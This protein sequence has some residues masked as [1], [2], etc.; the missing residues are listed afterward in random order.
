MTPAPD[1]RHAAGR[2]FMR[3]ALTLWSAKGV[4]EQRKVRTSP[5]KHPALSSG[6]IPTIFKFCISSLVSVTIVKYNC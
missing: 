5:P 1:A 3:A 4:W 6:Y 2:V